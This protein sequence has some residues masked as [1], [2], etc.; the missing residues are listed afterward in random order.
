MKTRRSCAQYQLVWAVTSVVWAVKQLVI[1][2]INFPASGADC[3]LSGLPALELSH[4]AAVLYLVC[5][6]IPDAEIFQAIYTYF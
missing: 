6:V 5:F 3:R 2:Q 1:L 4:F